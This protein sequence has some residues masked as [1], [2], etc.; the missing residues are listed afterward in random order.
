MRETWSSRTS[1]SSTARPSIGSSPREVLRL[2]PRKR[3]SDTKYTAGAV[4]VVGGSPGMAGA[5]TLTATAA[6]RADAGYVTVCSEVE[7][8]LLEAVKR[9]LA[10]ALDAVEKHDAIAI[11]PGLGRSAEKQA[12][13]RR[14]LEETVA[15]G[16]RRRGRPLRARAVRAAG[17]GRSHPARGRARTVARPRAR[18][19]RPRTAS[20]PSPKRPSAFGCVCLLKGADALVAG[21][22]HGVLVAALGP[23]SLATAG[24]GDVPHRRDRRVSSR[25]AW[26]RGWPAVAAAVACDV[27]ARLGPSRGLVASDVVALL[28]AALE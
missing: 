11:G 23:P 5:V 12:L 21:P 22:G 18:L 9:P 6:F 27:A 15:A 16:G 26:R 1:G 14:L 2:V 13:V 10:E 8:H 19:D 3:E 7:P 20:Q 28:P 25:R 24:T 4:L 17:R